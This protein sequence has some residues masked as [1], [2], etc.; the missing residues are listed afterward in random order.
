MWYSSSKKVYYRVW[1]LDLN[2]TKYSVLQEFDIDLDL[3][4]V[5]SLKKILTCSSDLRPIEH[6][7]DIN[8]V[9][10]NILKTKLNIHL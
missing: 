3:T 10:K 7:R 9:N 5:F 1:Y 8:Q 6:I 2:R 4:A